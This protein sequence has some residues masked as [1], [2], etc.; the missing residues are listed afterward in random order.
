MAKNRA[1]SLADEIRAAIKA[2]GYTKY[3]VSKECGIHESAVGRFVNRQGDLTLGNAE[4]VMQFLGFEIT[5]PP[6][7]GK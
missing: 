1:R 2:Q 6:A 3:R 7:K 4:R 5:P